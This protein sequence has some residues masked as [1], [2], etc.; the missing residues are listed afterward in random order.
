MERPKKDLNRID[1]RFS[2]EVKVEILRICDYEK[3]RGVNQEISPVLSS[4]CVLE[5]AIDL[6]NFGSNQ[7]FEKI[8]GN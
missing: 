7:G 5:E 2:K 3:F 4:W 6:R 1:K 8:A